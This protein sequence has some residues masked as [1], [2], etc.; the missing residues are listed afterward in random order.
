ML[1]RR[2][3]LESWLGIK[4]LIQ[5]NS[6][7]SQCKPC[8]L[9]LTFGPWLKPIHS[10]VIRCHPCCH[11][12]SKSE[13]TQDDSRKHRIPGK[14]LA[15]PVLTTSDDSRQLRL[16]QQFR[17][18]SPL[19]Y[20]LSYLAVSEWVAGITL[21]SMG[22]TSNSNGG[23]GTGPAATEQPHDPILRRTPAR[24]AGRVPGP[25]P[26]QSANCRLCRSGQA[27]RP[28]RNSEWRREAA[29]VGDS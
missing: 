10:P 21:P 26:N 12:M 7:S 15:A 24:T 4:R 28:C 23:T 27:T 25:R 3:V 20:Q 18:F 13:I 17:F 5:P 29:P 19:L 16:K 11:P 14:F 8:C 6:Y 2:L 9:S 1:C 22:V